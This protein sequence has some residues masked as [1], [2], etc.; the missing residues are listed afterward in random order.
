MIVLDTNVISESWKITPSPTVLAWMDAQAV[1]TLYLSAITV[2]ELRYGIAV[3]PEG[4]RKITYQ[5]K[6]NHV[7]LPLFADRVLPFDLGVSQVYA[8]LMAR[9]RAEGKEI[10]KEDSYI[11]ATAAM[12]GFVVAT[13]DINPFQAA[14]LR[15]INPWKTVD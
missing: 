5:N 2:A 12:H 10:G 13:R 11:A 6:L 8:D 15:V 3:M 4:K 1:E 14:G 9:A 7:V